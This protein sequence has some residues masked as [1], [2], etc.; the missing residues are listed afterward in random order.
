MSDEER[1]VK[2]EELAAHQ[3]KVIEELSDQ[4]AEQWKVIEQTRAKLDRLTERF[5]SLEESSLEAPPIT[6]P[7]HY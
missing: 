1:L 7:P 3:T 5:L 2:L 4:L 6:R